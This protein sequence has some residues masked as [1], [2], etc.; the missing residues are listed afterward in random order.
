VDSRSPAEFA[1]GH[2]PGSINLPFADRS[3]V[4]YAGSFL[5]YTR[6]I[7]LIIDPAQI[8][9]AVNDL[10]RI[11]LE[12]VAGYFMPTAL[13]EWSQLTG[14]PLS[15][16]AEVT[17]GEVKA[18][19]DQG[20]VALIDVR[21]PSEFAAGH[22]PGACNIP[23]T[24]ILDCCE[25]IP[26]DRPVVLYCKGGFRSSI[27]AGLLA[28]QGH[29]NVLNLQGGYGAWLAAPAAITHRSTGRTRTLPPK[30]RPAARLQTGQPAPVAPSRLATA[31]LPYWMEL[32][33]H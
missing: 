30:P 32:P 2:L 21:T 15:R 12:Q 18:A 5:E 29:S 4:T 23:L 8:G 9:A 6:A 26:T 11:G 1:H 14:Q 22:L 19:I 10:A 25:A 16:L 7:Y 33:S 3:F 20:T 17:V 13:A 27:A 24:R 28:S 31:D